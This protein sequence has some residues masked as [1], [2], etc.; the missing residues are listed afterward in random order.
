MPWLCS[1]PSAGK[2]CFAIRHNLRS[3]S[4]GCTASPGR[5]IPDLTCFVGCF[6]GHMVRAKD[7]VI[8]NQMKELAFG[9]YAWTEDGYGLAEEGEEGFEKNQVKD[10]GSGAFVAPGLGLTAKHVSR[11]FEWLDSQFD[12]R[13]RRKSPLDDQYKIT[14][15]ETDFAT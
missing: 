10:A 9:Y 6:M 5:E 4:V 7:V 15:V 12:A 3:R 13:N 2:T 14:R 8:T 1:E 11:G